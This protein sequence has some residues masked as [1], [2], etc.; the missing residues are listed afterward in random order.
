MSLQENLRRPSPPHSKATTTDDIIAE[1]CATA[2]ATDPEDRVQR[3][4]ARRVA[5]VTGATSGLGLETARSLALM[6]WEVHVGCRNAEKGRRVVDD[7]VL[8]TGNE[9]LFPLI[10]DLASM[11]SVRAGADAFLELGRPL[12][13]LVNNA[14][15]ASRGDD[16]SAFNPD[17]H[18]R[19]LATNYF[20]P[21]VLTE[22]L[23]P[24]LRAS[25]PARVVNLAS[26]V[27]GKAS[28]K[29]A[30]FPPAKAS[31][32]AYPLSK[33]CNI[34]HALELHRREVSNG[35]TVVAVHPG[36]VMT[37]IFNAKQK[38]C[39]WAIARCCVRTCNK[40]TVEQAASTQVYC[41]VCPAGYGEHHS[42]ADNRESVGGRFFANCKPLRLAGDAVD[43]GKQRA[44]YDR[45]AEVLRDHLPPPQ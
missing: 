29:L 41:A 35:V 4:G 36:S 27:M 43:E 42:N 20:G 3:L 21:F 1:F 11:A 19:V 10:I 9:L 26:D 25:R 23:L 22:L 37:N 7:L 34:L 33:L 31:F 8:Q 38:S 15:I 45:T 24:V 30:S 40:R 16:E 17:G 6:H 5:I 18:E 14:G 12:H 28:I 13:L 32:F 2:T 44:L 39:L